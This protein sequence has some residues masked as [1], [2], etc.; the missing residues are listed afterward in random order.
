MASLIVNGTERSFDAPDDMPLLWALRDKIGLT[1]T[2]YGC[3]A[4]LCGACTVF[5]DGQPVR[6][7][8]TSVSDVAGSEILTIEG[9]SGPIGSA[10]QSAWRDLE[11]A[12]CGYCQSG[13]IMSAV[14]LLSE[15]P[16]PSDVDINLAMD[17]NI[18]RC[19]TYIRIKA[20]IH[21]ASD[22]LGG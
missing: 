11:V 21:L 1:G 18:C 9:L 10:V 17:A 8:S 15:I 7:C 2:K 13:Q 16:D 14:A 20:A 22:L 5:V 4:A 3:G 19:A 12:Q 6:S